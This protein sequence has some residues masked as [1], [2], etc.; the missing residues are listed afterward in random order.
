MSG[1]QGLLGFGGIVAL[2]LALV[3]LA[4]RVAPPESR[5]PFNAELKRRLAKKKPDVVLL[6]NS[7]V[8]SRFSEPELAKLLAPRR[9][10]VI[11]VGG[12]KSA[13]WY[14][15]LKN[16]ILPAARPKEI[17][18]FYRRREL[19]TP[20]DRATGPEHHRLDRVT[21]EDDPFVE[22]VLA[23]RWEQPVARIGWLLGRL[24]PVG[25]LH[26]L[27]ELPLDGFASSGAALLTG[28]A[29]RD[30]SRRAI[31]AVFDVGKLRS[32]DLEPTLTKEEHGQFR[33]ALPRSLLP[34][35][36]SS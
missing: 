1:R 28:A 25:R 10:A 6:G 35:A 16:I 11:G 36:P 31:E 30:R 14:L 5:Q 13:F 7:M 2:A 33:D 9:V 22:D 19:T 3:V 12:S 24:A 17:L 20:R 21:R 4:S 32:G 15:A 27:V 29:G 23:P 8:N 34:A 26:A 18:L